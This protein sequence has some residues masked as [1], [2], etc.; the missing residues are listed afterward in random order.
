MIPETFQLCKRYKIITQL[1]FH[2]N[3]LS[4]CM[5]GRCRRLS[6][7]YCFLLQGGSLPWGRGLL[8]CPS[9]TMHDVVPRRVVLLILPL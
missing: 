8:W 4:C 6:G 3:L 5:V 2:A 9:V 1:L 7:V